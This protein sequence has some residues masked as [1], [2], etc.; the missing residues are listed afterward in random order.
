VIGP[1]LFAIFMMDLPK[2]IESSIAQ[3]ADDSSVFRAIHKESD[4]TVLQNDLKSINTWCVNNEM[5]LNPSKS[6]HLLISKSQSK[7]D[8]EY[9]IN[10]VVIPKESQIKCLGVNISDD[11]KWSIHTDYITAKAFRILNMIRRTL[12]GSRRV[13]LRTAY[14]SLVR[15]IILYGTPAWN[16]ITLENLHKIERVQNVATSLI[17]GK[18][19]YRY[20]NGIKS[21][22]NSSTRNV[23]CNIP[24]ITDILF[25]NDLV[26]LHKCIM[27]ETDLNVFHPN[28]ITVRNRPSHLRGGDQQQFV[29]PMVTAAYYNN[30][31]IPRSVASYNKLSDTVKCLPVSQFKGAIT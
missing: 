8:S 15:P 23:M 7:F 26:F 6:C 14:L 24:S 4:V 18:D 2:C 22:I 30:T 19:A 16:P 28:R 10:N 27:G 5:S 12:S 9:S 20:T 1:L 31:F 3:Y 17:L 29:V 11:M 13:A 21:K 25:K